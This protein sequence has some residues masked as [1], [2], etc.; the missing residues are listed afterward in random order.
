MKK[1]IHIL[2][3]I[4]F[5]IM[6]LLHSQSLYSQSPPDPPGDHGS[7]NDEESGGGAPIGSGLFIL[8]GFGAAYGGRKLYKMNKDSLEE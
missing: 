5:L 3:T 4:I 1:Y 2:L 6:I 7:G 8:L